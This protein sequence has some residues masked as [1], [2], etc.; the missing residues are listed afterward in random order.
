MAQNLGAAREGMGALAHCLGRA[1]V[2]I[3]VHGGRRPALLEQNKSGRLLTRARKRLWLSGLGRMA[4]EPSL[5]YT[6]I[7]VLLQLLP[8]IRRCNCYLIDL[9]E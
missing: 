8:S 1:S 9:V 7:G 2:A 4:G 6:V 5:L 3:W